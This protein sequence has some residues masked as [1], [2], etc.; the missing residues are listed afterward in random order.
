MDLES[1]LIPLERPV[2]RLNGLGDVLV[3]PPELEGPAA[4]VA[5]SGADEVPPAPAPATPAT[6]PAPATVPP[7]SPT[8]AAPALAVA[9]LPLASP[10]EVMQAAPAVSAMIEPDAPPASPASRPSEAPPSFDAARLDGFLAASAV[11]EPTP[12]PIATPPALR[13]DEA[14]L[15][16]WTLVPPVAEPTA[17]TPATF[18]RAV[19]STSFAATAF[20]SAGGAFDGE[21]GAGNEPIEDRLALVAGRL[22]QAAERLASAFSANSVGGSRPR[23]FRGR[24]DG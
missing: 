6:S 19:D 5:A 17:P 10:P 8:V 23:A 11:D 1:F 2:P 9:E 14:V 13:D 3:S 22:E 24:I 18:P 21:S 15:A 16:P 7:P 20:P 4:M 12:T